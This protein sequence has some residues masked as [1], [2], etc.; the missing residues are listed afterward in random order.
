VKKLL[1]ILL[2]LYSNHLF[3]AAQRYP[4]LHE[5]QSLGIDHILHS[6]TKFAES[7]AVYFIGTDDYIVLQKQFDKS[8]SAT[9][10]KK[11]NKEGH[12]YREKKIKTTKALFN[13]TFTS[14]KRL[15]QELKSLQ[16]K[17]LPYD[18]TTTTIFR[19]NSPIMEETT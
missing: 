17:D 2:F 19:C 13:E 14:V 8:F 6:E 9:L 3:P 16:I 4:A 10:Y 12:E 15:N 7:C 1:S 5:S 11:C 18:T